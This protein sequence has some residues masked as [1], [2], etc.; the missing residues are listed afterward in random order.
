[1]KSNKIKIFSVLAISAMLFACGGPSSSSE[2]KSNSSSVA[3]T[4]SSVTTSATESVTSDE[5]STSSA[6]SEVTTSEDDSSSIE[7]PV[8][9]IST[10][11]EAQAADASSSVIVK[12][13]VVAI[14]SKS[15][16]I[17]DTTGKI[18]VWMNAAHDY[19][20][21]QYLKVSGA[22][23]ARNGNNQFTNTATITVIT[24]ETAPIVTETPTTWT[25]TEI[26]TFIST[27]QE[28]R[29][30]GAYITISGQVSISGSYYNVIVDGTTNMC[31]LS[32]LTDTQKALFES[33]KNYDI[34]GYVTDVSSGKY[35]NIYVVSAVEV[36]AP[37]V[38]S[39]TLADEAV[40][41]APGDT[42]TITATV[43]PSTA[44]QS[45]T[46]ASS[47][48]SIATVDADG[49]ITAVA[50]GSAT[51]TVSTVGLDE[52]GA[53]LTQTV[54]V[55][56]AGATVNTLNEAQSIASSAGTLSSDSLTLSYS[57]TNFDFTLEKNISNT[58]IRTQDT[59][60]LRIYVGHK[61]TVSSKSESPASIYKIEFTCTTSSYATAL[62]GSTFTCLGGTDGTEV[63]P[64]ITADGTLVTVAF[65]SSACAS[66]V[67]FVP[68]KQT[69][70]NNINF[71]YL[72]A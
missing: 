49:V 55:T 21:G 50:E 3:G 15:F 24:D 4:T 66:S 1:M 46:F 6:T 57:F 72:A 31:S 34:T 38:T 69:R 40:S 68:T 7:E 62:E 8:E 65:S 11:A 53:S 16:M 42:K 48:E 52:A 35:V 22:L 30:I 29:G 39:L 2:S 9:V 27:S 33:G 23:T 37:A 71:I 64:T 59:D 70:I 67:S 20:V 51:I 54:S 32:Y 17:E 19:I 43:E 26:D 5:I 12:G 56:V 58:D 45:L 10:I 18:V 25:A 14:T 44:N 61:A 60:H 63:T 47:D 41:L 28:E 13:V 36:Q